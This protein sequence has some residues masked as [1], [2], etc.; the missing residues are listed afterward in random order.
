MPSPTTPRRALAWG[1]VW[2]VCVWAVALVANRS[3]PWLTG[4]T[5]WSPER[6]RQMTPLA[7]WDS[8]WYVGIAESGYQ[9]PPADVG[10]ETNHAFFPLYPLLM[11][12]VARVTGLETSRAGALVS[13]LA[14][15]LATT[16]FA[17]WV[18]RGFGEETVRPAL[19]VFLLLPTSFFFAAVYTESLL[20][21]LSLAAVLATEQRRDVRA[22]LAGFLAGLTRVSGL[23]LAPYLFLS[24]WRARRAAGEP[25]AR[26]LLHAVLVGASPLAGFGLFC[27]YFRQRFGDAFLFVRAQHNWAKEPK[28]VFD[29]PRLILQ[30]IASDVTTGRIFHRSPARTMEVVLL[31]VF[32]VLAFLLVKRRLYPEA[33]YVFLTVAIVFSSGTLESGGRY[34]L[35]AFPAFAV[36][37]SLSSRP[38]VFRAFLVLCAMTQAVYVWLFVHW[39]WVG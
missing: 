4:P 25:G 37:A 19:F 5:G 15:L 1:A 8:G 39:L 10:R 36:L 6:V 35:P 13:A 34:V 18:S 27:L 12:G 11:R 14:L 38:A 33:V 29:G 23:V 22:A 24:S 16:L 31:G 2:L 9:A 3:T 20:V 28:T 26:A 30:T 21:F 7:R 32:L 17:R